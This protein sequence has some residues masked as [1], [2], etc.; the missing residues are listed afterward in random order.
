MISPFIP[1]S[2][3]AENIPGLVAG[4]L[5][6][7]GAILKDVGTG[8]I[9][10]H[11]Q[12]TGLLSR[13]VSQGTGMLGNALNPASGIASV[14]TV[15]QNQQIKSKLAALETSM[16]GIQT[17]QLVTLATSVVG[18]GVTMAS[19]AII[20]NKIKQLD[21]S[22]QRLEDKLD[23][24][25]AKWREMRVRETLVD[26][27]TSLERLDEGM[28]RPDR[29]QVLSN[30]E[31]K[32]D[33]GFNRFANGVETLTGSTDI[34]ADQL[35]ILLSALSIC[36]GAQFKA[37]LFLDLKETAKK[38]ATRQNR[39][40][41]ALTWNIP[42]DILELRLGDNKHLASTIANDAS[43]PRIRLAARPQMLQTLIARNVHGRDYIESAE[44]EKE[45]PLLLLPVV[46][47]T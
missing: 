19:T 17:L 2:I 10:A 12:E 37:L 46:D 38:R 35:G 23:A 45:E 13:V 3:A 7:H 26:L 11:L 41:E 6:R 9:V 31:E 8:R 42:Q 29:D 32:L 15:V 18:I 22:V 14:F 16:A 44:Q 20:L 4:Q 5:V 25:P 30:V 28:H 33:Y 40:I 43:E 47:E 21:Q 27:Q 24:M 34:D 36:A 39:L 1:F